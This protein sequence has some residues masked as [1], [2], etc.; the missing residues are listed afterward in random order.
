MRNKQKSS[1]ILPLSKKNKTAITVALMGFI[2]V[3]ISAI[4]LSPPNYSNSIR[5]MK[6]ERIAKV[7]EKTNNIIFNNGGV[8]STIYKLLIDN[9]KDSI[10]KTIST[11]KKELMNATE[12]ITEIEPYFKDKSKRLLIQ[13]KDSITLYID[14]IDSCINNK[15]LQID[16]QVIYIHDSMSLLKNV[17]YVLTKEG[18]L[19]FVDGLFT[20]E[21]GKLVINKDFF[22]QLLP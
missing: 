14:K 17:K 4:I 2:S 22:N 8:E 1:N 3:V 15:D 5:K 20:I 12:A 9:K 21:K 18:R 11:Y 10:M 16:N 7:L 6:R 13:K 19:T